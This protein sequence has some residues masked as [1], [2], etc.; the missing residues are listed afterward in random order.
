MNILLNSTQSDCFNLFKHVRGPHDLKMNP[1]VIR[2]L[3][4]PWKQ[5]NL[6][7]LLQSAQ[8]VY[9]SAYT[10]AMTY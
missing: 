9:N 4:N 3:L 2:C 7:G 10:N 5:K 1:L 6:F 8:I